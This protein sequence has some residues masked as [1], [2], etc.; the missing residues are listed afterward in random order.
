V[1][2]ETSQRG[3]VRFGVLVAVIA[4]FVG[5]GVPLVA[6][7]WYNVNHLLA[8]DVR[9]GPLL[10]AVGAAAGLGGVLYGLARIVERW[11]DAKRE[12]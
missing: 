3:P 5:V 10:T 12:T 2:R 7:A 8:G 11:T 6:L 9:A 4:G 1:K